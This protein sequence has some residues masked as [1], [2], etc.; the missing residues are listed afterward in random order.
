[1][2]DEDIGECLFAGSINQTQALDVEIKETIHAIESS[3]E[4]LV[5]P[6]H[7]MSTLDGS[8]L[9]VST[10]SLLPRIRRVSFV[11]RL[12]PFMVILHRPIIPLM[13]CFNIFGR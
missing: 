10:S 8:P 13:N 6:F 2:E 9:M 5:S 11:T 4:L 7:R 1:M 3:E 12:R